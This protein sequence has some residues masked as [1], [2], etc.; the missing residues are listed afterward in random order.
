MRTC[1]SVRSWRVGCMQP[2]LREACWQHDSNCRA[3]VFSSLGLLLRCT[4][5]AC[6]CSGRDCGSL[7]ACH[8]VGL[9][10]NANACNAS[11]VEV[12]SVRDT[13]A[14]AVPVMR[15]RGGVDYVLAAYCIVRACGICAHGRQQLM[16]LLSSRYNMRSPRPCISM[17]RMVRG[18]RTEGIRMHASSC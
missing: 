16:R 15:I 4:A 17:R 8:A 7:H 11:A 3:N 5:N 6:R 13:P 10:Q 18:R 12:A 1:R 9:M 14:A 2:W